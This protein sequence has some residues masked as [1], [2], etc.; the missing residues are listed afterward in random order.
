MKNNVL[1][2][3]A[4]GHTGQFVVADLLRRGLVP[5]LSGRNETALKE[6]GRR[7]PS[8]EI[9]PAAIDDPAALR[10]AATEVAAIIN[11]A[12]PFLDTG[13]PVAEAAARA[14]AHY[15][16]VTAEQVA[17]QQIYQEHRQRG[18]ATDIAMIPSMAFYGG[19]PDLLATAAASPF[20]TI[21]EIT[22]AIGIDRWWPT[23][24]TRK[25]GKR[26]TAPRLVVTDGKLTPATASERDWDFAAPLGK[27]AVVECPFS[28]IVTMSRHLRASHIRTY[29]SQMALNDIRDATTTAPEAVDAS[30]RSAQRFI[31][32]VTVRQGGHRRRVT[33]GGRDIYAVT[34]PLI[35][36]ATQRL[37]DGRAKI[38]GAAAPGETFDAQDF[39]SSLSDTL[40]VSDIVDEAA[41]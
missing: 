38:C 34:A 36:E 5:I 37:L 15:L 20:T 39:L 6:L 33:A 40:T 29:L 13:L 26:N 9:R 24:G 30:G 3:G 7:H 12:G 21:D 23:E 2:Y 22:I 8:L 4:Y 1:V 10:T 14:G 18:W 19:L 27:H 16:D 35:T 32:E 17:A 28:E 25:T 31:V 11:T 41:K